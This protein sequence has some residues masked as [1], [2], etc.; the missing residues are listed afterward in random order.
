MGSLT[1]DEVGRIAQHIRK[2]EGRKED[3]LG[4]VGVTYYSLDKRLPLT[5]VNGFTYLCIYCE[6]KLLGLSGRSLRIGTQDFLFHY[7]Y[8]YKE[9]SEENL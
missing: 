1:P 3:R 8:R 6:E 5:V 4:K 9:T 2:G 7:R